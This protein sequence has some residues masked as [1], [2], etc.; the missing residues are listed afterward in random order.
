MS[1]TKTYEIEMDELMEQ[2]ERLEM[3]ADIIEWLYV[4]DGAYDSKQDWRE[5]FSEFLRRTLLDGD[6]SI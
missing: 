3:Y 5:S 6:D 4:N 2:D 1:R